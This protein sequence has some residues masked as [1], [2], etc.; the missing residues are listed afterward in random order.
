[1][2]IPKGKKAGIQ[3]FDAYRPVTQSMD[4]LVRLFVLDQKHRVE[5]LRKHGYDDYKGTT[6]I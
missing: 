5:Q 4:L 6:E 3:L 2:I 1:M